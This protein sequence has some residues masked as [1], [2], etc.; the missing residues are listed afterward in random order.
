MLLGVTHFPMAYTTSS[1]P[2]GAEVRIID[3][4]VLTGSSLSFYFNWCINTHPAPPHA[5]TLHE[6]SKY[7]IE[8][9]LLFEK[10]IRKRMWAVQIFYCSPTGKTDLCWISEVACWVQNSNLLLEECLQQ[11]CLYIGMAA[12][13]LAHNHIWLFIHQVLMM[14]HIHKKNDLGEKQGWVI[15]HLQWLINNNDTDRF[16]SRNPLIPGLL[17]SVAAH[18]VLVH[19]ITSCSSVDYLCVCVYFHHCVHQ[20]QLEKSLMRRLQLCEDAFYK[21][22][23]SFINQCRGFC[24]FSSF[25][26]LNFTCS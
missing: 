8:Y 22:L 10:Y 16:L 24:A 1:W 5:F 9:K 21:I 12:F 3:S 7:M 23:R 4:K 13:H 17:I 20:F 18:P 19:F 26:N 2:L 15:V 25:L 11:L 14:K 6:Y